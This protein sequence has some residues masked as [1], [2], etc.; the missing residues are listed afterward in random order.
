MDYRVHAILQA[1]ILEWVAFPF[2]R[3]S[4]WP[5][6]QIQVSCIAGRFFTS[7]ATRDFP[8]GSDGK[9]STCDA[10]DLGSIPGLRRSP[11]EGKGYPL[12][13]SCLENSMDRGAWQAVVHGVAKSRTWLSNFHFF[14]SLRDKLIFKIP[15]TPNILESLAIVGYPLALYLSFQF[16]LLR[17][18]AP[19]SAPDSTKHSIIS[20]IRLQSKGSS[21]VFGSRSPKWSYQWV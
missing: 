17:L 3:G 1:R 18:T 8:G 11:A 6:D 20:T 19:C 4:S 12:Q 14:F 21:Q 10:W 15:A 2:S 7:W 9:E 16:P 13:Y 5:R